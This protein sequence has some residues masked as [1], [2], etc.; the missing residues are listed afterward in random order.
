VTVVLQK[1]LDIEETSSEI[2][3]RVGSGLD[4][5]LAMSLLGHYICIPCIWGCNTEFGCRSGI[6]LQNQ[7]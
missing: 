1:L 4:L 5:A 3:P 6:K 2:I 7:V